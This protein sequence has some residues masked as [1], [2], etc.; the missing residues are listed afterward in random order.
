MG[1]LSRKYWTGSSFVSKI[2]TLMNR[3]MSRF[4]A[5]FPVDVSTIY[6]WTHYTKKDS[7]KDNHISILTITTI[8]TLT[9]DKKGK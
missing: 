2:K 6:I 4:W 8:L 5:R 7:Q 1:Y 3:L 9:V